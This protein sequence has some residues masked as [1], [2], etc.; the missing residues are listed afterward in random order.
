MITLGISTTLVAT[1]AGLVVAIPAGVS[2]NLLRTCLEKFEI[3]RS[4]TLRAA[5]PRS[6][7]FAQTLP[8]QRRFSRLPAF[9]L[10]GA[11]VLALLIPMFALML[12]SQISVGL[13]VRLLKIGVSDRDLGSI[14]ISVTSASPS[15]PAT[16]FVNWKE[17]L[18]SELHDALRNQLRVRP[19]AIV[20]VQAGNEVPWADVTYAI[21]VARGL[22]AKV[23]MLTVIPN[24][25][26]SHL[27]KQ[28]RRSKVST[29]KFRE[30][31]R[32]G[33]KLK[34]P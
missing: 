1:A 22:Q 12:R 34:G 16:V 32:W 4:T 24:I 20:Y 27:P 18:W 5:M 3:S 13:P 25:G 29:R 11:P 14:V 19:Y 8:L 17:T 9:A 21:D 7:G 15:D 10:I 6:Y 30:R 2:Y 26:S 31:I 33:K 23:V 28:N